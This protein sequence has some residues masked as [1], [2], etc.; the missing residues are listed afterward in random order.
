[1]RFR[2]KMVLVMV[3]LLT[4]SYGVGGVLLIRQNFQSSLKQIQT[5]AEESYEMILKSIQLVNFVDIQQDLSN[6]SNTLETMNTSESLAGMSLKRGE[7]V[8]YQ[9]GE[10]IE[11]MAESSSEF[12]SLLFTRESR[13]L[14]QI[15]GEIRTNGKP[16]ELTV[17]YDITSVYQ[18]RDAQIMTYHQVLAILL[19]FGG[20]AAWLISFLMT[21][22]LVKVSRTA[23]ALSNGDLDA[24]VNPKTHDEIGQLG[25]DFD[26]MADRLSD[27]ISEL[28]NSMEH[29]EMFMGSFAHELKTPMT[30][31]IGYAD[32][33]R[34]EALGPEES[35]EAANYIFSEGKRLEALSFKL[36]DLLMMRNQKLKMV[37]TDMKH[38]IENL[39]HHLQ[40]V[41]RKKGIALQCRCEPGICMVEPDLFGSVIA[42]LVDNSRKAMDNGGNIM[43][44]GDSYKG[45]YRIRVIDNGRGMPEEAIRHITEAFYRVD[46]SRSRAQG[47]AGLGLTLCKEII[48]LHEGKIAF[49]S[50][51]GNGTCVTVMI[52]EITG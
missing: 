30:S 32:L 12:T 41:Y 26:N 13:H 36:L 52:K 49:A 7:K 1:M 42:N 50:R 9:N 19:L 10:N 3:W 47:G 2:Q 16:L 6:I 28:K 5:N 11:E 29:Q 18:A 35:Q 27:N 24:R 44:M 43:I 38:M 39:T 17:V 48:N 51:E 22:P 15:S 31:I 46:K 34:S 4:L 8:L 33:I 14:Y 37:P 45:N 23:R 21:K 40:P 20:G 25:S